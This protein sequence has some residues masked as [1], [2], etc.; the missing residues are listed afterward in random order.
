MATSI[1]LINKALARISELPLEF[2][3]EA[4][5]AAFGTQ[6]LFDPE[7]DVQRVAS[8]IYP[9]VRVSLLYA[10]PWSWNTQR[11]VL[12]PVPYAD[13]E[14]DPESAWPYTNRYRLPDPEVYSIRS[15]HQRYAPEQPRTEGW[16]AQ[17]GFLFAGFDAHFVV[18]QRDVDEQSWPKLFEVAVEWQLAAELAMPLKE[19]VETMNA[20]LQIAER[21][22]HD[23]KRVDAQSH[24]VKVIPRFSWDEARVAGVTQ[25]PSGWR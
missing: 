13:T 3:S 4:A 2:E 19:D 9:A 21:K 1:E 10:H 7:D 17:G 20:Y 5:R 15:V 11:H 6:G 25:A 16:D 12:I 18:S 24:P 14:P 8:S 22:L 23:A